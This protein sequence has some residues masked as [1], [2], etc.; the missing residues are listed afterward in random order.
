MWPLLK[1]FQF[2]LIYFSSC[3]SNLIH[4][5]PEMTDV[6]WEWHEEIKERKEQY[7]SILL[8]KGPVKG[9]QRQSQ[10][11]GLGTNLKTVLVAWG[12]EDPFLLWMDGNSYTIYF[13]VSASQS[14]LLS[15]TD[16]FYWFSLLC[17][18]TKNGGSVQLW[19]TPD[20]YFTKTP[21]K[22]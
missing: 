10:E 5:K 22:K 16:Y 3:Q 17:L 1:L 21:Q 13:W 19:N 7:L 15:L 18:G 8:L 14:L 20:K 12:T 11:T 4:Q 9:S 6:L 2:I